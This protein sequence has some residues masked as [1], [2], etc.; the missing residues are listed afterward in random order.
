MKKLL[1]KLLVL[2]V[3]IF[4]V[5]LVGC[6]NSNKGEK[7]DLEK[8]V[9][10]GILDIGITIYDPMDYFGEDGETIVGFDADLANLFGESLG[11]KVRFIPIAWDSKIVEL[12]S[13]Y[14]DLIW[15]G[16]TATDELA[17]EIDLSLDYATNY[18]CVVVK[19]ENV[20][21]FNNVDDLK[22]KQ[23]AVESGSA[24]NNV[25]EG[26]VT[27]NA[28]GSQLDAL[29]EVKAGTSIACVIDYTMAYSLIGKGD[30]TD[31]AIIDASKISFEQEVFAVGARKNSDII[32]KLN[33]FFKAKYND[34]TLNELATK[35]GVAINDAAFK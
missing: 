23:I 7:T 1:I 29:N 5:T 21:S 26:I 8:I 3:V 11:V 33:D 22:G 27:P 9:E 15:N 24:G 28:V 18:Q 17:K 14:I 34:G 2:V 6:G 25:L 30:Y 19:K 16:M 32:N 31:L 4:S 10:D 35:Y 13:K 20:S 12:N